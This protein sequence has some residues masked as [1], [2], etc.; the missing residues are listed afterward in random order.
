MAGRSDKES[1]SAYDKTSAGKARTKNY[2]NKP[3]IIALKSTREWKDHQNKMARAR[4]AK[5][6][7]AKKA[8]LLIV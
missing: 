4:T 7:D 1:K 8:A 6:R 2:N 3:E 5:K